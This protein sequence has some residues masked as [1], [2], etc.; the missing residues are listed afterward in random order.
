MNR[1][2]ELRTFEGS[3]ALVVAAACWGFAFV[4]SVQGSQTMSFWFFNATRFTLASVSLLPFA[5]WSFIKN[6]KIVIPDENRRMRVN[7][8]AFHVPVISLS[9]LQRKGSFL[10]RVLIYCVC[11]VLLFVAS[12]IQQLGLEVSKQAAHAGFISSLYIIAVPI[13]ARIF[14]HKRTSL[15][16]M[17]GIL[18]AIIG[19]YFLS[20]PAGAGFSRMDPV[21]LI[22]LA[23]A[24]L[25]GAH[26]VVLD[27]NV[28]HVDSMMLSFV[29]SLV[30]A[31]LSW[32]G[33]AFDGSIN[34]TAATHGWVSIA[35]TGIVSVG[36][37]YTLQI[38]G[39]RFVQ[40]AQASILMSLESLFSAVGGILILH[41]FMSGRAIFGSSLIFVGTLLSQIPVENLRLRRNR[42]ESTGN[43]A[44]FAPVDEDDPAPLPLPDGAQVPGA[45]SED[46]TVETAPSQSAT[47]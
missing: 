30:V 33:A 26:I 35:Y 34:M 12:T 9:D 6:H 10:Y 47:L 31:I 37:A 46:K 11:G 24:T 15:F 27:A 13:L 2:N 38:F 20:I 45:E 16:T 8:G 43:T 21:D 7:S 25:F 3:V 44:D 39:Q 23:S 22:F 18:V 32:I 42:L 29:Q 19:F 17:I 4:F 1:K 14:L 40:P 28:H 36:V 41:E 5:V